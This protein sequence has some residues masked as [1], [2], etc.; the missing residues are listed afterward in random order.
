M[1]GACASMEGRAGLDGSLENGSDTGRGGQTR[2]ESRMCYKQA[3]SGWLE[4]KGQ[5]DLLGLYIFMYKN[6]LGGKALCGEGRGLAES[7]R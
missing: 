1:G 4:R 7:W 6:W 5:T 3:R 2:L